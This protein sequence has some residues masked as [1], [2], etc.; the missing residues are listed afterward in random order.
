MS[1][2]FVTQFIKN[3]D[4]SEAE[5]YGEVVFLTKEEYKPEPTLNEH[6]AAVITEMASKFSTY[7]PGEDYIVTTG[8]SIPNVI[9]GMAIGTYPRGTLHNILKWDNR[10]NGYA[11][12][13]LRT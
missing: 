12:Y 6:N 13:K 3:L 7:I 5:K 11:L 1:K 8:S 10:R 9:I 2:V 4:F